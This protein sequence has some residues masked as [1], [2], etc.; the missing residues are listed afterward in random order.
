MGLFTCKH[1]FKY[2]VVKKES[3]QKIHAKYPEDF[4]HITHHLHCTNCNKDLNI[5]YVE[6]IEEV[7]EFLNKKVNYE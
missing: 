4:M 3:T 6:L 5:N 1:K 7:K 2:L